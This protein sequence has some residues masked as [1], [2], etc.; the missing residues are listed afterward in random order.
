MDSG[1]LNPGNVHL[2]MLQKINTLHSTLYTLNAKPGKRLYSI[3][4]DANS[5]DRNGNAATTAFIN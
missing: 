3:P 2:L 4:T 5:P 1:R